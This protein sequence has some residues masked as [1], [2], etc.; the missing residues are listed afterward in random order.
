MTSAE[1]RTRELI[2]LISDIPSLTPISPK[3]QRTTRRNML[4]EYCVARC[5]VQLR[6]LRNSRQLTGVASF[7]GTFVNHKC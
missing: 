7:S 5:V 3:S 1:N 2:S 4:C 6:R